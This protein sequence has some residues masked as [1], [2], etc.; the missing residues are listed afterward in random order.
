MPLIEHLFTA[1]NHLY[2]AAGGEV[3]CLS[4]VI[5][6]NNLSSHDSIPLQ[7]LLNAAARGN[8]FDQIVQSYLE[9]NPLPE[10]DESVMACFKGFLNFLDRHEVSVWSPLQR[11]MVWNHGGQLLGCTPDWPLMIDGKMWIVDGKTLHPLSGVALK[12]KKLAFRVQLQGQ[13]E[14]FGQDDELWERLG[15]AVEI[16]K[17]ILWCNPKL[18][19]PRIKEEGAEYGE[20]YHFLPQRYDD[21]KLFDSCVTV[22]IHKIQA[23]VEVERR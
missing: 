15:D 22:A 7:V 17:A 11:S 21:S 19:M 14:A 10:A 12:L 8:G 13:L 20:G 9:D 6:L 1:D 18:A 2:Q 4:D 3:L 23:G 16:N 5:A